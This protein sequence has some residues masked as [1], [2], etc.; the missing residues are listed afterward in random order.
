MQN[1]A[2]R[3]EEKD[4]DPIEFINLGD[5][6]K[7]Q[8]EEQSDESCEIVNINLNFCE[9]CGQEKASN[10]ACEYCLPLKQAAGEKLET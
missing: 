5:I 7:E 8:K 4:I 1:E 9:N 2:R 3:I 10:N 6:T